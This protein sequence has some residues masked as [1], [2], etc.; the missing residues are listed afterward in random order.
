M[1][2]LINISQNKIENELINTVSAIEL[3]EKLEVKKDFSSWI[4]VQIKRGMFDENIDFITLPLKGDSK[5][6]I[7]QA[8]GLYRNEKGQVLKVDYILT[9]DTAKH[10]A[11]MSGTQKGKDI[12]K[13]FIEAEKELREIKAQ[14]PKTRSKEWKK[15]R[16]DG[17]EVRRSLTDTVQ[18]FIEYAKK[19]GST[20]A[21]RYYSNITVTT[22]KALKLISSVKE[23]DEKFRDTLNQIHL[24]FLGTAE[25]LVLE[26][27]E[28]EMLKGTF[29][30]EIFQIAKEKVLE[31]AKVVIPVIEFKPRPK[32]GILPL[33]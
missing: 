2:K 7:L 5:K 31:F 32:N 1:K 4:K 33:F 16:Q 14:P 3:H 29:Y 27:M 30:K 22:Y 19:Q 10:I 8:N 9:I 6:A 23:I 11:M 12:R 26:I 25:N 15:I 28:N 18:K 13:F 24:Q 17:K 21:D 20:N